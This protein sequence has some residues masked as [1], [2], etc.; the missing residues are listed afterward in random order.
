MG[1]CGCGDF[2]PDFSLPGPDGT[3][4]AFQIWK[5]CRYCDVHQIQLRVTRLQGDSVTDWEADTIEK[6]EFHPVDDGGNFAD[7]SV[8][9]LDPNVLGK[10]IR[11]SV[12]SLYDESPETLQE[13]L[14]D[15]S[16]SEEEFLGM[17][18]EDV[19]NVLN[20]TSWREEGS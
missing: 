2:N 14:E 9:L 12:K 8:L 3:V 18:Q 4:Y 17:I 16:I 15:D 20:E 19:D 1:Q 6:L 10:A 5:G 7:V 11:T 13:L